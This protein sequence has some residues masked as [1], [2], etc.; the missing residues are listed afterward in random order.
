MS[1][2]PPNYGKTLADIQAAY[3][4]HVVQSPNIQPQ[5]N[6]FLDALEKNAPQVLAH[7]RQG[8]TDQVANALLQKSGAPD[9]LQGKGGIGLQAWQ[10]YQASQ[11]DT[12]MED[13]QYGTAY[14]NMIKAQR[15]AYGT[16]EKPMTEYQR[17]RLG[18]SNRRE[19]R[20]AR[21]NPY[22]EV[23]DTTGHPWSDWNQLAEND[24]ANI[25][26]DPSDPTRF[27]GTFH[28][29]VGDADVTSMSSIGKDMF[30]AARARQ[31]GNQTDQ[32]GV[33][34][35]TS[36]PPLQA[37]VNQAQ[38]RMQSEQGPTTNKAPVRV[39]TPE[40]ANALPV[41]TYYLTPDGKLHKR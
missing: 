28:K 34:Q 24:L 23:R 39:G 7:I 26:T 40:E 5:R 31:G 13:V 4:P 18:F 8:Q 29:K 2:L 41:G 9:E 17:Q 21:G 36:R 10:D 12:N 27:R 15:D 3:Q 38:E 33:P 22:K 19:D 32:S 25:Q 11:P 14:A 20:L 16:G 30:E 37:D 6:Q 1:W 35:F